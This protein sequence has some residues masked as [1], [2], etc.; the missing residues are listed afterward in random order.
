MNII[1]SIFIA[2]FMSAA[3]TTACLAIGAEIIYVVELSDHDKTV[4]CQT[5][6]KEELKTATDDIKKEASLFSKALA[7]ADKAWKEDANNG[8]KSFPKSAIAPRAI[9]VKTQTRNAE[10]AD[11]VVAK[12]DDKVSKMQLRKEE[13]A[14]AAKKGRFGKNASKSELDAK[15]KAEIERTQSM[16]TAKALFQ[17]QMDRLK[18]G[19]TEEP[20][21]E[22]AAA[23]PEAAAEKPAKKEEGKKH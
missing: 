1:K 20:A 10:E 6:T 3:L 19:G 12:F 8:R 18:A 22:G 17:E 15:K 7:A 4:T 13:D 5:M 21:A 9:K 16:E 23:E 11:K 14:E 2:G